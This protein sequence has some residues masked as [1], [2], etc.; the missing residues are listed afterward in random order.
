MN[1]GSNDSKYKD[2][3]QPKW[4]ISL[5]NKLKE[6]HNITNT[7]IIRQYIASERDGQ[8]VPFLD[9]EAKRTTRQVLYQYEMLSGNRNNSNKLNDDKAWKEVAFFGKRISW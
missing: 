2:Y 4:Y 5:V 3:V 9:D 8:A 1:K 7:E 6:E